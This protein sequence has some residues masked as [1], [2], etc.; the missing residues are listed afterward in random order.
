MERNLRSLVNGG[1]KQGTPNYLSTNELCM[2]FILAYYSELILKC[3]IPNDGDIKIFLCF[4]LRFCFLH[5]TIIG[6]RH[7]RLQLIFRHSCFEKQFK[8][9]TLL[10][11]NFCKKDFKIIYAYLRLKI[12]VTF[13]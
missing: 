2:N 12:N 10:Y 9:K 11:V 1:E 4:P 6:P 3:L 8:M 13:C 7:R 5:C